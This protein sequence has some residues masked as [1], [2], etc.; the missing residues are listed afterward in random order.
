MLV[1]FLIYFAC[2]KAEDGPE[3]AVELSSSIYVYF[4]TFV[5]VFLLWGVGF[6]IMIWRQY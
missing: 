4:F 3:V 5:I 2:I 6:N 1:M